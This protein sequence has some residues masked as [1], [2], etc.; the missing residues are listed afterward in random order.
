MGKSEEER[1]NLFVENLDMNNIFRFR[2]GKFEMDS[3]RIVRISIFYDRD[4]DGRLNI[5]FEYD[6]VWDEYRFNE[7]KNYHCCSKFMWRFQREF[8]EK[9]LI[10]ELI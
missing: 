9:N 1:F 5:S 7:E 2:T 6:N 10:I 4:A 8:I 3:G